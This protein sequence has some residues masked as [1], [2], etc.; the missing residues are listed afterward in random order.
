VWSRAPSDTILCV[1][2]IVWI[3]ASSRGCIR[4]NFTMSHRH[5]R[6]SPWPSVGCEPVKQ[7]SG[8]CPWCNDCY[9]LLPSLPDPESVCPTSHGYRG[10]PATY[11]LSM[12]YHNALP[13]KEG[14]SLA[15]A[16]LNKTIHHLLHL[17]VIGLTSGALSS[18]PCNR[19][20]IC[21]ACAR[22]G[23][24]YGAREPRRVRAPVLTL[25]YPLPGPH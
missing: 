13:G 4:A 25:T 17:C 3:R 7:G 15:N 2:S 12:R 19:H 1:G 11:H 5:P 8:N 6:T 22:I 18:L 21:S 24:Y 10:T 23:P 16:H 20:P 9:V 14:K